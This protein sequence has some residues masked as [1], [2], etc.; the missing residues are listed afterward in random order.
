M[1]SV[2]LFMRCLIFA[3]AAGGL[4]AQSPVVR[5]EFDVVSV[6]PSA[7][8]EHNSF[9]FRNMP[10]GTVRMMGT[11]LR[12][13]IMQAYD[14]KAFQISGGPDWVRTDRWDIL[15]KAEGV[16][17]RL[18]SAQEYP[19]LRAM[20]EDRFQ[21]K[22]HSETKEMP[23]YALVVGKNGPKLVPNAGAGQQFRSRPTIIDVKKGGTAALAAWL[24]RQVG[25]V[26]IDKTELK[27][28]YDY[29]LEYVPEP[30]QGGAESI[31]LPPEMPRPHD[32]ATGPSIFTALQEQLG[33]R[34]VSEKGP[35]VMVVI[36]R[37]ERPSAN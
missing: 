31:G 6:K 2:L 11:P 27:G 15:A 9:E 28:E 7:P 35:V 3:A 24:S 30:G 13:I 33:L 8:D 36:D 10:G 12:M 4:L 19:M 22:T 14:V 37:V 20:M 5:K 32:E 23:V 34:L 17:G 29:T 26:V 25:R 16:E 21:L 18:P 1:F